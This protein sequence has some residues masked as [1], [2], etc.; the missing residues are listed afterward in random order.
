M[1]KS[2]VKG[3]VNRQRRERGQRGVNLEEGAW[4]SSVGGRL[5]E[6]FHLLKTRF[7]P[8]QWW[9]ADTPLEVMVGAVLTQNTNWKNVEKAILNLKKKD[10]L[11]L[12]RLYGLAPEALAHEIRPAGYY[13]IKAR[14][15]KN[16][17]GFVMEQYAGDLEALRKA[18]TQTLRQDLLS[19]NGVG[20]ETAD[21]ILLY[22]LD[23]PVFVVDA[24]THR[25]LSRHAMADQEETYHE[26][27][28][29]FMMHLPDDSSLYNE[30][31]ALIVQ[32]GKHYCRRTP[33]CERCPLKT[34]GDITLEPDAR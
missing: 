19:V 24:Y 10:L 26:L 2:Q 23:R 34:W 13:N 30:F 25:I 6:M 8:Q 32:A 22:A 9:P 21:S 15:L 11:S 29:L 3:V 17:I 1:C 14:R 33:L 5:R 7:G 28:Q 31:H 16:L 18:R 27:Q 20:P 4:G 12:E